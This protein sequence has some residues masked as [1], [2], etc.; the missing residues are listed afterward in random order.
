MNNLSDII[1]EFIL[2]AIGTDD[3]LNLSRNE[4]ANF[5]NVSPSQI[6]YVLS[7]RF[8]MDRGY[9][10]ESK[11]GGGGYIILKKLNF[12]NDLLYNIIKNLQ[13]DL[14]YLSACYILENLVTNKIITLNEAQIIKSAISSKSLS[15]PLKIENTLRYRIMK[16][17]LINLQNRGN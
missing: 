5:F 17:I 11:R 2:R 16:N 13:S 12:D 15:T 7:T 8:T 1:E 6:N 14:D 4:L 3:K 10:T 9:L